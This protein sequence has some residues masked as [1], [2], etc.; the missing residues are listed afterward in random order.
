[1]VVVQNRYKEHPRRCSE[2]QDNLRYSLITFVLCYTPQSGDKALTQVIWVLRKPTGVFLSLYLDRSP[3]V[4]Y[5]AIS[6]EIIKTNRGPFHKSSYERFLLYEFVEPVLI[7]PSHLTE[8][9]EIWLAMA[10][11]RHFP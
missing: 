10:C 6:Y 2:D 3:Y 8:L 7:A 9:P 11:E 5:Y 1:M 4:L